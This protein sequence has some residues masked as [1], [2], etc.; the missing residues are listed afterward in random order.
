MSDKA[1]V[2]ERADGSKVAS[3]DVTTTLGVVHVDVDATT[4]PDLS[5][6]D[7]EAEAMILA[8]ELKGG[9]S[10]SAESVKASKTDTATPDASTPNGK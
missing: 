5:A 1:S 2:V 8:H 4:R 7:A 10:L 9:T 3:F 6:D